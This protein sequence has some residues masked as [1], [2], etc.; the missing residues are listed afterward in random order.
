VDLLAAEP[1]DQARALWAWLVTRDRMSL[2]RLEAI[3][4]TRKYLGGTLQ[5]RRLLEVAKAGSLSPAEDR[6]HLLFAHTGIRGWTANV[7]V[8]VDGR[9]IAV[10]D[11]LFPSARLVIEVDGWSAHGHRAAF[12]RDRTRQNRLIAAGYVVLRFTWEDLTDRPAYVVQAVR[13]ALAKTS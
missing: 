10:V 3:I 12:Q 2:R 7:P 5:L 1:W 11:V 8:E 6:L 13:G 4:E 9:V